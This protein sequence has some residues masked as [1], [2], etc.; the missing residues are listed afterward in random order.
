VKTT[1]LPE[2]TNQHYHIMLYL[3]HHRCFLLRLGLFGQAVSE[4]N[5]NYYLWWPSLL[6]DR[7]VMGNI[8]IKNIS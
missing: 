1:D 7:D 8:F 3:V 4:A 5:T 2:V 6:M